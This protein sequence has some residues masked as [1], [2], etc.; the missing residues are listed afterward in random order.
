M[1]A[2]YL[3]LCCL[4]DPGDEVI[5]PS[6]RWVNSRH[7]TMLVGGISFELYMTHS[8]V[9]EG[10]P[11]VFGIVSPSLRDQFINRAGTR[12]MITLI[13]SILAALVVHTLY[14]AVFKKKSA[15]HVAGG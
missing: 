9:N 12:F 2:I 7:M 3:A 8:F 10:L 6:P 15:G 5:I 4:I 11:V 13:T 1:E 14:K